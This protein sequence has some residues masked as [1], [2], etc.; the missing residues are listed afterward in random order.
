MDLPDLEQYLTDD[1]RLTVQAPPLRDVF[2]IDSFIKYAKEK[3]N[4]DVSLISQEEKNRFIIRK[5]SAKVLFG[6]KRM[7][8]DVESARSLFEKY[9]GAKK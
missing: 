9:F 4:S 8:I 6:D 5:E 1:G 2:D 3:Y 7:V